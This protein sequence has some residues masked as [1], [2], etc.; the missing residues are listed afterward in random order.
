M[1]SRILSIF[2]LIL[3]FSLVHASAQPGSGEDVFLRFGDNYRLYP[4][5]INQTEVF[6]VKSP[7]DQDILFSSCNTLN[8]IPF[9]I[10]E[11][12]YVT[13]DGGASWQGNDTC[14]GAPIAF[15]GGDPGIAIDKKGTFILTRLGRS[16]FTGLYSH[17]S[18]DNGATWSEQKVISTD[19]LE[20]AAAI[21]DANP[22]SP[23]HGRTFAAWVKFAPPFP[24][25]FAYT[26]NGAESWTAPAAVNNPSNRSA[27]GD[28]AVGPNGE[29]YAC[30][31][32]VT[33]VTPFKE[34]LVGFASSNTGGA[35]WNVTENAFPVNGITGIL[36]NK[37]NIRVNGLPN[38]DVD[39][40]DGPRRGWIY[41]VTGQKDLPP[42]G[43]DPDVILNRST[44]GGLT[45]SAGIRVNQDPLDNGKEQYFPT[46][47]VDQYGA[48]NIIYYDDRNT[49]SD[50]AGVFLARSTDGGDTWIEYPLSGHNFR[51]TP[52]GGLGQ[53]YQGD[54]IDI[55][56]TDS[57][58]W[59]V[60]MDNS[61]GIYQIWTAPVAFSA[62]Q[63]IP[64]EWRT[65]GRLTLFPNPSTGITNYE[66]RITNKSDVTLGLYDLTGTLLKE[67]LNE[68]LKP[69]VYSGNFDLGTA[70][71]G[72]G[73]TPG[74][75]FVQ[76][77]VNGVSVTNRLI[78]LK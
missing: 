18:T 53:G 77:T 20:R 13:T 24:L 26:D 61:T 34:I 19:D 3:V 21:S 62:I 6:I 60:W 38:M 66:L 44:D 73:L 11:G 74:V 52:I 47:H 71:Q 37:D 4:S 32:G 45:W 9:F 30:W 16:P 56:S 14:T 76:L 22:S 40:T 1:P 59:P 7:L 58:L 5:N 8:F 31:A 36:P 15:H 65:G 43:S 33:A 17:Y 63:A 2:A 50:S 72:R 23:Y 57:T 51:P 69:G 49:T 75:Y 67:F 42:A 41:I 39:L 25:M 12:I 27:G 28:L 46:V 29:I 54:N 48:V 35:A 10:S 64:N 55:T 68:S 78:Y 70:N